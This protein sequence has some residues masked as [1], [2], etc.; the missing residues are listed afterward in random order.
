[1]LCFPN[2]PMFKSV[3]NIIDR[4]GSWTYDGTKLNLRNMYNVVDTS[5][6]MPH[7]YWTLVEAPAE[8]HSQRYECCPENH[9]D[10]T[11][12]LKLRYI[13]QYGPGLFGGTQ[14]GVRGK[15]P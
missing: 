12:T 14:G 6:Y 13:Y 4:F 11:Y 2:E 10:I 5:T 3:V 7:P 1:M 15:G 9:I 8:R